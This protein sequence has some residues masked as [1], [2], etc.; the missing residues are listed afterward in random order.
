MARATVKN[1]NKWV[2]PAAEGRNSKADQIYAALRDAIIAGQLLPGESINKPDICAQLGVS[3]LPV[4][5]AINRL[6]FERLVLIEPQKGSF[7]ARIRMD[8]VRQWMMARRALEVEVAKEAARRLPAEA[9]VQLRHNLDYQKT[10]MNAGD[11]DGFSRLDGTF[12]D[13]LVGALELR[14]IEEVLATLRSHVERVRRL[15]APAPG[16]NENTLAEHQAIFNA[17]AEHDTDAAGNAMHIHL[18]TVFK[19]VLALESEHPAFFAA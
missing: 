14:R 5:T 18:E 13:I 12:H 15:T 4:T 7:V 9:L 19:R 16:H 1:A 3:L 11:H 8:D 17:I 2:P 6:A 10:A